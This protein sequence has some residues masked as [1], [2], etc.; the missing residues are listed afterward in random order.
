M[1]LFCHVPRAI[2][3]LLLESFKNQ[4]RVTDV[5]TEATCVSARVCVCLCVFV[6]VFVRKIED[7]KL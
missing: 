5:N 2:L 1:P 7:L 3:L 6:R 4:R